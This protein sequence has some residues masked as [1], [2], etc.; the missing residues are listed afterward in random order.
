M[1]DGAVDTCFRCAEGEPVAQAAHRQRIIAAVEMQHAAAGRATDHEARLEDPDA[2]GAA[3][4]VGS[5]R[6]SKA[7]DG[8]NATSAARND[9]QIFMLLPPGTPY[10]LAA[11]IPHHYARSPV[12]ATDSRTN[13]RENNAPVP[14]SRRLHRPRPR[15]RDGHRP[16][17]AAGRLV[18]GLAKPP[19]NPPNWIFAPVW[20]LLYI[21]VA[22]A[23]WRTWQR[24]P[25]SAAMTVWFVQLALNFIWS[26]VFF[27][28]HR[29]GAALV[30]VTGL[31]AA[32][33]AFIMVCWPRDRAAACCSCPM[34]PGWRS[35]RCSMARSGISIEPAANR[36]CSRYRISRP[37]RGSC[38]SR[39]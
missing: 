38:G 34:Q 4:G 1:A 37:C 9:R 14:R 31:L 36:P 29:P 24:G 10:G 30:I 7:R 21:M 8:S 25:R 33:L 32:I 5:G 23:G 11:S 26:P 3:V 2:D 27:G 22:V 19:F 39:W 12:I 20:T 17:D 16:D 15:R 18:C 13:T 6:K 28:A 35:P